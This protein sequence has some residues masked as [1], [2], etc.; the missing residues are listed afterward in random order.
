MKFVLTD[1]Q[2]KAVTDVLSR[3]RRAT[4]DFSDGDYS[5]VCL[6]AATGAGKT[7]IAAAVV[8]R[9][10]YGDDETPPDPHATVLWVTD[11]PK[12]N[13]QT[14]RKMLVASTLIKSSQL[15]TL[16]EGFDSES[17][18]PNCVYFLNIQKLGKK[19]SYVRGQTDNRRWSFWDTLATTFRSTAGH[20]YVVI[21]EAHRGTGRA[22]AGRPTIV[23]RLVSDPDGNLPPAPIVW[24]IS[25]TPDRFQRAMAASTTPQ[26]THRDVLVD[27]A[28]V[29]ASGLLKDTLDIRFP[30][31]T[32]PSDATLTRLAAENLQLLSERWTAYCTAQSEPMVHPVLVVQVRAKT[33]EQKISE[34]LTTLKS[35]WP[36]LAGKAVA[37]CF[38]DGRTLD[39]AGTA[40]RYVAPQDI[41]DDA[42]I[43]VVLFKEALTTGWDCPRAET[44]LSFRKA[45]DHTYI[46]QLIG[47]MV[48]TPLARRVE[49]DA[50]LNSVSMYLPYYDKDA[51]QVIVSRL[52]SDEDGPPLEITTNAVLCG[53]NPN[54][55]PDVHDLV[56]AL[57]TYTVPGRVHRSQVARLHTLA[58]CLTGDGIVEKALT[59]C[60]SYLIG[61]LEAER[62]R[63]QNAGH[64]QKLLA[65]LGSIDIGRLT[66][67]LADGDVVER[68]ENVQTDSRDINA[69]FATAKR[70]FR[71]G[72]AL[73][74]WDWLLAQDAAL[75]PDDAK[76]RVA[77]LA[78]DPDTV[79]AVESAAEHQVQ[80]WLKEHSRDI[81]DLA[82]ARRA[83]YT[84]VREQARASEVID[85]VFSADIQVAGDAEL[86][87]YE[88]HLFSEPDGRF[89]MKTTSWEKGVLEA[90]LGRT[91]LEGWYRNPTGGSRALRV[92]YRQ[93]DVD[94]PY[95]PDFVFVHE[96]DGAL[97]ASIVDPH[98]YALADTLPKWRGLAAYAEV[99]GA[100]FQR[101]DAVIQDP[102]GTL[103]RLDFT[104]DVIRTEFRKVSSSDALLALFAQ[105][106]GKY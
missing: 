10:F 68:A 104:D 5:S 79:G 55:G 42:Q 51:V 82:E 95:Y 25:A 91:D 77:A 33:S 40:L 38:E 26:R 59:K 9:L 48:R 3:L 24:G 6:S 46:A 72:L 58:T 87:R 65:D 67:S 22:D 78:S 44:M 37:H 45:E 92:P 56:A 106:G 102:S 75:L 12:L 81:T 69:V 27:V 23:R 96:L 31:E 7:V 30:V 73:T 16:D 43:R 18:G 21:D 71:D 105:Q 86:D 80:L 90:E 76:I 57:P 34:L 17:L 47:R 28:E 88:Q 103:L 63:L 36:D 49:A 101:I 14:R 15:V 62:Q 100:H 4:H 39:I 1:Y 61:I 64:F 53:L 84:R 89:P 20:L 54:L 13:E 52:R 60:N 85:L 50:L 29:R 74:Y 98:S 99:H 8:E 66:V 97:R 35:A 11:D 94:K 32:Q 83:P 93:G 2:D 19:T 41:Q 70:A